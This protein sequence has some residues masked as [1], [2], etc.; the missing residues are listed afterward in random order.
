MESKFYKLISF[1]K[2]YIALYHPSAYDEFKPV[3]SKL[4]LNGHNKVVKF[5]NT[6]LAY[7]YSIS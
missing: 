2:S 5:N 1:F 4:L 7:F 3:P 6:F